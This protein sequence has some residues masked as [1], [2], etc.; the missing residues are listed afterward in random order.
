MDTN[1]TLNAKTLL[2]HQKNSRQFVLNSDLGYDTHFDIHVPLY[3]L[4]QI[5][6][7]TFGDLF[8]FSLELRTFSSQK[9]PKK[10]VFC[11]FRTS[12]YRSLE[13][14]MRN[15]DHTLFFGGL[16]WNFSKAF[17]PRKKHSK[18]SFCLKNQIKGKQY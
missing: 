4:I 3:G 8:G 11:L 16:N 13:F 7:T 12:L 6:M 2:S 9:L 17:E 5:V 10:N 18:T 14:C 15:R 1:I